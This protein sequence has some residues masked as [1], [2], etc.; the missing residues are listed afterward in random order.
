MLPD[1]AL[2]EIFDFYMDERRLSWDVL[3][4]VCRKWRNLVLGS[5]RRLGLRLYY[6]ARTP[7]GGYVWPPFPIII[8]AIYRDSWGV[9]NILA[10]LQHNDRICQLDLFG[11]PSSQLDK[12]L[13]VMQ[14]PFPALTYLRIWPTYPEDT[15]PVPASFL[16]GCSPRLQT[17][18]LCRIPFP[19]LPKLILSAT[20]LATLSLEDIPRSGYISPEAM[21]TCLSELTRLETLCIEF[22]SPRSFPDQ[23]SPCSPPWTRTLLPALTSLQMQGVNEYLEDFVAR[24]DA[25]LLNDLIIIFY[26]GQI[27]DTP[28]VDQFI[29]RTPKFESCHVAQVVFSDVDTSVALIP[30]TLLRTPD[31][32]LE[33]RVLCSQPDDQ[34]LSQV[35]VCNSSF[36]QAIATVD[37]LY[38]LAHGFW[39]CQPDDNIENGHWLDF[40]RPFTGVERI[41]IH[42]E[43]TPYIPLALQDL[44]EEGVTEVLPALRT[45]FLEEEPSQPDV[46][47]A[48]E[49]FVAARRL[50]GCPITV[51]LWEAWQVTDY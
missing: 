29:G 9:D 45:L 7:V 36:P 8:E 3:V 21:V 4:F 27:Y 22:I 43:F 32:R 30:I 50:A 11:F 24:I 46:R 47:D 51:S 15:L 41:Y 35:E 48:I 1:L 20:N 23:K 2:L 19:G 37:H 5:P 18:K 17:L 40:L 39:N 42:S 44:V 14:Q 34:L 12:I 33:L 26:Y 6:D 28:Q 38:L 49:Q 25:P 13:A 16:N 10:A 31:T